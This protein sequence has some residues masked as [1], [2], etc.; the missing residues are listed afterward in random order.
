MARKILRFL[1]RCDDVLEVL[2]RAAFRFAFSRRGAAVAGTALIA[3]A[4]LA[5]FSPPPDQGLQ[6]GALAPAVSGVNQAE[7]DDTLSDLDLDAAA[8]PVTI[9]VD[10][11]V[12]RHGDHTALVTHEGRS[13]RARPGTLIPQDGPPRFVITRVGCE[14]VEAHDWNARQSVT[15]RWVA[16]VETGVPELT[17]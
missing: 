12:G 10:A 8:Q 9:S 4:A 11:I 13:Y 1:A 2:V 14:S 6:P 7:L 3:Y 17:E 16:P 5:H 15:A